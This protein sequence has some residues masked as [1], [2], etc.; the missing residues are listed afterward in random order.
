MSSEVHSLDA[1]GSFEAL[2]EAFFRYYDSPFG[3]AEGQLENERRALLDKPGGIYQ[4]PL[5]E[6][7]PQYRSTGRSLEESVSVAGLKA[8][9]AAFLRAGGMP[10]QLYM[11]QEQALRA[12][13]TP[14]RNV[15]ITAGTGSG[16]TESFLLPVIAG[17]IDESRTW[18]GSGADAIRR[19]WTHPE[20]GFQAQRNGEQGRR[21][22]VRA[23][24][25]Y[26]MN[27]L[28]DDQLVRLRR[29]L[30]SAD[31]RDWLDRNRNG[32]RFYFGRYT[33]ATPVSG[34]S[35]NGLARSELAKFFSETEKVSAA[36]A[37]L[38]DPDHRYFVPRIGG[39]EM[40]S[41]WDMAEFPPDIMIT[42]YS[43][44]NVML[45]RPSDAGFFEA[46]RKWLFEDESNRF[47]LV[48][49]ELHSYRG[50]AGTEVALLLR[51]LKHRLGISDRPD[52]IRVLAAS[53]SLDPERDK[54]Y[55][56]EFFGLDAD[57][58]EFL[59]GELVV[60]ESDSLDVW[61]DPKVALANAFRVRSGGKMADAPEAKSEDEL[62]ELLYRDQSIGERRR[63][64][65]ELLNKASSEDGWPRLRSHYF[66]RNV[67]GMWACTDPNCS[68]LYGESL[69]PDRTVGCLY[70]EPRSRCDCGARVL[71]LLYCQNC[72][73]VLLGG[74]TAEGAPQRAQVKALLLADVPDLGRIPDQVNNDRLATNYMVYWPR[75][76]KPEAGDGDPQ[77]EV[78]GV[79]FGYFPA[80]LDPANGLLAAGKPSTGWGFRVKAGGGKKSGRKK[81]VELSRLAGLPT[82][83][84][85]CGDDWEVKQTRKGVVPLSDPTRLR[86]PIRT[87]RTG[88]EKINQILVTE[89][90]QQLRDAERKLIVFTDSRQDAAKLSS[91][92]ALRHYQ[93][94]VRI[95]LLES[96]GGN[97]E[98]GDD[99]VSLARAWVQD[100]VRT[101][102]AKAAR[103][104]LRD[105]DRDTFDRLVD[106]W[107]GDEEP[108]EGELEVLEGRFSRP[109]TLISLRTKVRD[110]LLKIGVNPGGPAPSLNV[111][112]KGRNSSV[113]WSELYSWPKSGVPKPRAL[114]DDAERELVAR[115]DDEFR[116]QFLEGIYSGAGRD[117]ESLGLGWI[118]L[119]LDNALDDVEPD[120]DAAL[121]RSSL[122]VLGDMRRFF[123]LR[124]PN[125]RAPKKLRE[126]WEA[127]AKHFGLPV[128]D[129]EDRVRRYW[130]PA[131]VEF[132]IDDSKVAVR[133]PRGV[134]WVCQMCRRP[135]LHRGTTLCTRCGR[136]LPE[137]PEAITLTDDY[138]AWKAS[139]AIGRFRMNAAELTGQTDRIDAQSRQARFQGVFLD[140]SQ[141]DR[142]DGV[143]LLSVTTTMEAG[144]DIG[145]LEAVVLG[146]MPPSR[147]N[148][149]QRVGRAGRRSSR[150]AIAMTVCRG[151]SHDEYYFDRPTRITN[152]P[153]P[154]PYLALDQESIFKRVLASET[155]RMA[156]AACGDALTSEIGDYSGTGT[157]THGQFGR[158]DEWRLAKP[159]INAW[160]ERNGDEIDRTA[161]ALAVN[162]GLEAKVDEI[163][164]EL[165]KR[166]IGRVDKAVERTSGAED[167]SQRLAENGILP[168]FGFP[169]KVRNL[170]LK[171]PTSTYP[172][173]PK[174]LIDRD[175]AMAVSQFAPGAELVRDGTVFPAAGVAAYKRVGKTVVPEAEPFGVERMIDI[176]RR[177]SY[178]HENESKASDPTASCPRCGAEPGTFES[179][180]MA[181]PIGYL[182]GKTRDFDGMFAWSSRSSSAKA[183]ADLEDLKKTTCE[184]VLAYSGPGERYVINDRGGELFRFQPVK[185]GQYWQGGYVSL[186]AVSAGLVR[187]DISAGSVKELALG[188][189][190]PTDL[191]FI[192]SSAP[193]RKDEGLRLNLDGSKLQPSGVPDRSEGRR[194]AWY[195]LAFLLRTA[196]ATFLD[197]QPP[198]L[199][200]GLYSGEVEGEAAL[201]AFVADTLENG[202]GF[203]TR[204]GQPDVF[205]DFLAAVRAYL[206]ELGQDWHAGECSSSCYRCLRD[207]GNMAFHAFL[208]WR[209][210]RDLLAVLENRT[211]VP[212]VEHERQMVAKWCDAYNATPLTDLRANIAAAIWEGSH[213][214]KIGLI[215]RHPLEAAESGDDGVVATRLSDGIAELESRLGDGAP[216]IVVDS[217]VL[218]RDPAAVVALSDMLAAE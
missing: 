39:A 64:V 106:I 156:F 165:E 176:C 84:P 85:N 79:T 188:S 139:E 26:P 191:L 207:Y 11:H 50:T 74:F 38:P 6:A 21:A 135:H 183:H 78:E 184:G 206:K 105:R 210:A 173:P 72:G 122:R 179:I 185:P 121:A 120:S 202:A 158:A 35:E 71:E 136:R 118:A 86:S 111:V 81:P 37:K 49:D 181:E 110:E 163:V 53:A 196:A 182:T 96:L 43:M 150:V 125:D 145:S 23:M 22:A 57:S 193:V 216:V 218:D 200:A 201:F 56:G 160:L 68:K 16:K 88:F 54:A 126:H 159:A 63:S 10:E 151:R 90:A 52:K 92:I 138:Y 119:E 51:N 13:T 41:R 152:D 209:L 113:R 167:L 205:P 66:F 190:Q 166:L 3:L 4:R 171:K 147:F 187:D 180:M 124:N 12:G 155:L 217:F 29:A 24:I 186:E 141:N 15:V 168:M 161:K 31:A 55:L 199:T 154:P 18:E 44:L 137:N 59:P 211:L 194:A 178:L 1:I 130:G 2:R 112:S 153:T 46:T 87:M 127:L 47:T 9:A 129:V 177:C 109:P 131:V 132:L 215:A 164:D 76:D 14:G 101:D 82:Q 162:T 36:A 80:R 142:P 67:P 146:N 61:R 25:M 75:K 34:S 48:V 198:E 17:L 214:G 100:G 144:V 7:R 60:P 195:S 123:G 30:D 103:K 208:D 204:L 27:A 95:L 89:L 107:S 42:N 98:V 45:L 114:S 83:C 116:K 174:N 192:G 169:T 58:F 8:E 99:L 115:I 197:V 140:E 175:A 117:F 32:H 189:V 91:G 148:Y 102:E 77:W 203:S 149:Q 28:V 128:E 20:Q 134:W 170:Y 93:D 94:L 73:D 213:V 157:N 212:D 70:A 69:F 40:L 62:G 5:I 97:E 133:K 108:Q 19:W 172:W 33:G 65:R 143:D 104:T